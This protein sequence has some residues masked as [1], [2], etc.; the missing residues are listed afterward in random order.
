MHAHLE[1]LLIDVL[2]PIIS[3]TFFFL[4]FNKKRPEDNEM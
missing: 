1:N 4:N 3:L 2:L